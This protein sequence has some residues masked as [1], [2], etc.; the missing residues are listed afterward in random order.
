MLPSLWIPTFRDLN[1][2]A[3]LPQAMMMRG[4][5]TPAYTLGIQDIVLPSIDSLDTNLSSETPNVYSIN[6]AV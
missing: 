2:V 5:A 4:K 3:D 6:K 1:W